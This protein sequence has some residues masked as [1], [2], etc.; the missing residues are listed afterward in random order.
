MQKLVDEID[1]AFG[2]GV[3]G[4]SDFDGALVLELLENGATAADFG[5]GESDVGASDGVDEGGVLAGPCPFEL[6]GGDGGFDASEQAGEIAEDDI[7]DGPFDGATSSVSED[8]HELCAGGRAGEFHTAEHVVVDDVA[9]DAADESVANAGIEDNFG[10]NA[11]IEAAEND[12]GGI[13]A[14]SA[15]ALFREVI[16][17]SHFG[18]TEALVAFFEFG[19]HLGR[20]HR[21]TLFLGEGVGEAGGELS[22]VGRE[23]KDRERGESGAEES[24]SMQ[25][26]GVG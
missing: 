26:M 1:S 6:G 10:G 13:L 7:I 23:G 19:D 14:G 15:G 16:A 18:R 8:E 5:D 2:Q 25:R 20:G 17:G 4:A 22:G 9:G 21:I 12:S 11:G 24:A 3:H